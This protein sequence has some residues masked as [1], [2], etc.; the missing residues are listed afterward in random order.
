MCCCS[1]LSAT[2]LV[3]KFLVFVIC[4]IF[5]NF[6]TYIPVQYN[7]ILGTICC[8]CIFIVLYYSSSDLY[9]YFQADDGYMYPKYVAC[10][11]TD[12]VVFAL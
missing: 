7:K 9:F 4:F 12:K 11:H 8:P 3:F 10:L 1:L 2:F 6:C 5:L